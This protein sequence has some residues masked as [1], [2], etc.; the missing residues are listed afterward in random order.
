MIYKFANET[1]K[2]LQ[3]L[4]ETGMGYQVFL[5]KE[6][7]DRNLTQFIAYNGQLNI[8]F[9]NNFQNYLQNFRSISFEKL[10]ENSQLIALKSDS[11]RIL[12][13]K[14]LVDFQFISDRNLIFPKAFREV[15]D[16]YKSDKSAINSNET[17]IQG[18]E[19]FVRVSA[20]ENDIR[21]DRVNVCLKPKSFATSYFDYL[22]CVNCNLDPI[23]RY[24]IPNDLEIMWAFYIQPDFEDTYKEG[25]VMPNFGRRGGGK[26]V[27]FEKGTSANSLIDIHAYG[28]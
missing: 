4:P 14:E 11:I 2:Q 22:T 5:A 17:K 21:I 3:K 16:N 26:E 28:T 23:D 24:A 8:R 12:T 10:L 7:A 13:K 20:F 19:M 27:Y 1:S 25:I 9:D 15:L 6:S 18:H